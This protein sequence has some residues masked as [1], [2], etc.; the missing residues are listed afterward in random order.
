MKCD[1]MGKR[2]VVQPYLTKP[3]QLQGRLQ[4]RVPDFL[5]ISQIAELKV[6][7]LTAHGN[8]PIAFHD[9]LYPTIRDVLALQKIIIRPPQKF[10]VCLI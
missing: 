7:M 4:L 9:K 3:L 1:N 10:L 6:A 2:D 8:I 5:F